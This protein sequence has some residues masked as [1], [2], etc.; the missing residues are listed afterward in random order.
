MSKKKVLGAAVALAMA[1]ILVAGF[2]ATDYSG[3]SDEPIPVPFDGG[4]GSINVV[5]FE[6]FGPIMLVLGIVMFGAIIS[7]VCLSKEE[8]ENK[9]EKE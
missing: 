4:E 6:V 7:G 1:I 2:I 5:L 8:D 9:E 3:T